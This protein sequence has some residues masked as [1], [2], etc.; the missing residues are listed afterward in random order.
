MNRPISHWVLLFALVAMWG[1]AFMLTGIAVRGLTPSTLVAVR[2][3]IAAIMLTVIALLL[4]H[5]FPPA[6]GFSGYP[7]LPSLLQAIVFP[8]G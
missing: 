2:L 7:V 5:R 3:L 4:A 1:S 6:G 8:F